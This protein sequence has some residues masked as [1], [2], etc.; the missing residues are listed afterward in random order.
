[1]KKKPDHITQEDWDAV[2]SPPLSE[3]LMSKMRPVRERHPD[4]P[5]RV[6]GPQRQPTKVP[7]SIRLSPEV[8]EYFKASGKGWQGRIDEALREYM[9]E[10][11]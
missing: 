3:E 5:R 7:V 10:H 6:R 2:D 1:M 4:M 11:R 8:V 9:A